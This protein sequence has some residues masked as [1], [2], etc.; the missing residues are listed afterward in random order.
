MLFSRIMGVSVV[1]TSSVARLW[2]SMP[3]RQEDCISA[4]MQAPRL[5]SL[6]KSSV[7]EKKETKEFVDAE[8]I[9]DQ[10]R[11]EE[12]E[13]PGSANGDFQLQVVYAAAIVVAWP[14]DD[15]RMPKFT[16]KLE[17]ITEECFAEDEHVPEN[18]QE[19]HIHEVTDS[20]GGKPSTQ[21]LKKIEGEEIVKEIHGDGS[22]ARVIQAV[23]PAGDEEMPMT[24]AQPDGS[25]FQESCQDCESRVPSFCPGHSAVQKNLV[26][27]GKKPAMRRILSFLLCH[28]Q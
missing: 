18:D 20:V 12:Y 15:K 2:C 28:N 16:P 1:L 14:K 11:A 13:N 10:V 19:V 23:S 21:A 9:E 27:T 25:D 8:V 7:E 4:E 3:M 6:I 5:Q 24:A 26:A 17:C 22:Q